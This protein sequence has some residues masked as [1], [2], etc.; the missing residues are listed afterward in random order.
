MTTA[1][2]RIRG[3]ERREIEQDLSKLVTGEVKFDPFSRVLY[4]TDASIYQMEPIGV[5]IPKSTDD[6]QATVQYCSDNNIP[7]L[8]RAGGTS[9]AGQTVNHA[10]V[11]DFSKYLDSIIEINQEEQWARVQPGI[12]LD[13]FNKQL[14]PYDLHY[15]PDPTTSS[16]ACVGGGIGNNTCGSHSVIYG[17]TLEVGMSSVCR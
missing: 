7:M 13:Q 10:V 17:K 3:N 1:E 6:V 12:I 16:R 15:A 2:A 5:V 8:P 4:S 9:L 14:A 11:I